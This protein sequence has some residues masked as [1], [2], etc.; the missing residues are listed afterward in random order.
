[1][2]KPRYYSKPNDQLRGDAIRFFDN[3][4]YENILA[5]SNLTD[6]KLYSNLIST[7]QKFVEY[8]GKGITSTQLRNIFSKIK[9]K[10]NIIDLTSLRPVL[11][12]TIARQKDSNNPEDVD[13]AK[14][15]ILLMDSLIQDM[16]HRNDIE[17][18]K[19]IES[20]HSF[21]EAIVGFHKFFHPRK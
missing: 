12:Y 20:F 16:S 11:A 7:I 13:K 1:M 2:S 8:T 6:K 19:M 15:I 9:S 3:G 21:V 14:K 5:M 10:D 4:R 18:S 17:D